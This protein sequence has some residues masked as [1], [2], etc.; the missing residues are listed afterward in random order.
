MASFE[1]VR[2]DKSDAPSLLPD[3]RPL[4]S[5]RLAVTLIVLTLA[6]L[7]ASLIWLRRSAERNTPSPVSY[8]TST[9]RTQ[10]LPVERAADIDVPPLDASDALTR[11]LVTQLSSHPTVMAWLTTD[12][13]IRNFAVVV[14]NIADRDL[15]SKHLRAVT[16]SGGFTVITDRGRT[17]LDPASYRRYDGYADAFEAMDAKGAAKLYATLK[18]RINEAFRELGHPRDDAADATLRRA[19]QSLLATPV[20]ETRIPLRQPG[21]MYAF[22]DPTLESLSPAQRQLLRMG[23]RN[24]RII[25]QKLRE[26]APYLGID[27]SA[28]GGTPP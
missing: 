5:R 7:A 26:I 15:P 8:T 1:D 25:Q 4:R 3:G 13:L 21:V 19:L 20:I 24:V 17:Y 6:A 14:L 9:P 18:P 23:P 27:L 2:L 28:G 22:E 10:P 16:P 11:Q 12:N